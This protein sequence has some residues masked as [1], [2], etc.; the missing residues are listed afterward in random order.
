MIDATMACKYSS[1][2]TQDAN[3]KIKVFRQIRVEFYNCKACHL[4][5]YAIYSI[6]T[7]VSIHTSLLI[8]YL[9][10]TGS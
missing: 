2:A 8:W 7:C 3:C 5:Q 10:C 1:L 9:N 6:C 4:E